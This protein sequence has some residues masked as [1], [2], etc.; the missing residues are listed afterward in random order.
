MQSFTNLPQMICT[1]YKNACLQ[2]GLGHLHPA[3]LPISVCSAKTN[4]VFSTEM[5][6]GHPSR[7]SEH[8]EDGSSP[9]ASHQRFLKL[10]QSS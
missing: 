10:Y 7:Q 3:V 2:K 9:F 4:Q 8:G 5:P 1:L 6:D